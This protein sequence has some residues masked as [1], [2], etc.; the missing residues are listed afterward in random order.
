MLSDKVLTSETDALVPDDFIKLSE[1][2]NWW[3]WA[4]Q[5]VSTRCF[6]SLAIALD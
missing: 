6:M 2:E 5:E 1:P 4:T 3:L